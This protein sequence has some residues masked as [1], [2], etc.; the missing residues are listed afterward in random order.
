LHGYF[1]SGENEGGRRRDAVYES[2][3]ET[4]PGKA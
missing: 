3:G 4:R 2:A 1:E